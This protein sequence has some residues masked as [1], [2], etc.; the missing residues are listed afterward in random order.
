MR[1]VIARALMNGCDAILDKLDELLT[2]VED[3]VHE[4]EISDAD[5]LEDSAWFAS[6]RQ[7]RKEIL[8]SVAQ[9]TL[10][11]PARISGPHLRT[12]QVADEE[13]VKVAKHL[14]YT[15]LH[16]IVENFSSDGALLKYAISIFA[17]PQVQRLCV[18]PGAAVT[19]PAIQIESPGGHGDVPKLLEK[20]LDE[21]AARGITPRVVVVTDSDSE[22]VG[23]VKSHAQE[24][25]DNC[26]V[27][28]VPCP[29]LNKRTAENYIPDAIWKAWAAEHPRAATAIDALCRLSSP[30][31]DHVNISKTNS[32]P[33]DSSKPPVHALFANVSADDEALLKAANLKGRGS[34]AIA[35]ILEKYAS[36]SDSVNVLTR[37]HECE[38]QAVVRRITDEL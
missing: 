38:L 37:D 31:R 18:G 10:Y 32:P 19:P 4:V 27:V 1:F 33:W 9:T 16:V 30:Q 14:A 21:A 3:E 2:R 36:A 28:G 15:P 17:S 26:A 24:L 23:D 8:K 13:S 34:V 35:Y 22:W 11:R 12:V 5:L 29:P 25:R 20:R 7:T 6:C